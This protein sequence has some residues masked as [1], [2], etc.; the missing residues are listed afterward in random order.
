MDHN[1]PG[2][3]VHGSSR[4][5][6]WSGWPFLPP[7]DLPDPGIELA[8]LVSPASASGFFIAS[9][10]WE[11]LPI[12]AHVFIWGPQVSPPPTASMGLG[13]GCKSIVWGRKP[14]LL[15]AQWDPNPWRRGGRHPPRTAQAAW[16]GELQ[17]LPC[18]WAITKAALQKG[19][20]PTLQ[21]ALDCCPELSPQLSPLQT[22]RVLPVTP[23]RL[24]A[25]LSLTLDSF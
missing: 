24:G 19:F 17:A 1:S 5:E 10:T 11:A 12:G 4:Q 15:P 22:P 21:N 16:M 14:P 8:S 18:S 2:S 9:A 25:G 7:G 23:P 13:W 20:V 3:S 6:Y